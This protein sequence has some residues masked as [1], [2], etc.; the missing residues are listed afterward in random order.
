[1]KVQREGEAVRVTFEATEVR[2]LR[3]ALERALFIDTPAQEQKAIAAFCAQA[4][5]LLDQG[6]ERPR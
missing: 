3:Y 2:L 5:E 1:M 4:L 6:A